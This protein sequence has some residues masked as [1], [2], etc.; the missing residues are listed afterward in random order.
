MVI[1]AIRFTFADSDD[2]FDEILKPMLIDMLTTML[3][4]TNLENRRLALGALISATHNK[5]HII[6]PHLAQLIPLVMKESKIKPELVREVQMGPFKHKVD[7]GLEVRKVSDLLGRHECHVLFFFQSAYET[8][9]S[10]MEG[11]YTRINPIDLFDRVVAGLDDEHEIKVLCYL[12]LTKL[13]VLDPEESVQHLDAVAE[14]FRV[15]LAFKTKDNAVKQEVEK[16][17]EASKGALK[18][19]VLLHNAFPSASSSA[20][21][22]HR[23]VWKGY[24]ESVVKEHRTQLSAMEQEVKNEAK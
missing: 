3:N 19:T 7:D 11:A 5:S 14:R 12:M 10:L 22:V 15:I 6:L 24:W 23:Q 9:Y 16:A 18:V 4:D 1:Q 21:D 13:I 20:T 8:L 17:H 2:S